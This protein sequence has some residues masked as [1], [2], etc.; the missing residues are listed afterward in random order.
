MKVSKRQLKSIIREERS[1]LLSEQGGP[2]PS[3]W[4]SADNDAMLGLIQFASVWSKLGAAVQ[5]QIVALAEASSGTEEEW[6]D[7]VQ[8]QNPNAIDLTID[9][10]E[11]NPLPPPRVLDGLDDMINMLY[12]AQELSTLTRGPSY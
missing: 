6:E 7:A 1:K 5:E 4:D 11:G 8:Q 12:A 9:T 2:S 10:F 3:D